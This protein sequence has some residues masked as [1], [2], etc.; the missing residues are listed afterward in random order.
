MQTQSLQIMLENNHKLL[1][2][3]NC[4]GDLPLTHHPML[5]QLMLNQLT[6]GQKFCLVDYLENYLV[7]S[8]NPFWRTASAIKVGTFFCDNPS[9]F[10]YLWTSIQMNEC[11]FN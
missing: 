5:E 8:K 9:G 7:E 2:K 10:F 6:G 3:R 11:D 4:P 1:Q